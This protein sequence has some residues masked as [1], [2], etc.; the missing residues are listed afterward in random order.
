MLVCEACGQQLFEHALHC[1][2]C[3]ADVPVAEVDPDAA[4]PPSPPSSPSGDDDWDPDE[5]SRFLPAYGWRRGLRNRVALVS[6]TVALIAAVASLAWLIGQAVGGGPAVPVPVS[7]TPSVTPRSTT[8]PRS[9]VVCTPE[10]ARSTNTSCAVATRVLAAVRTI[11]TDLPD[12][13]RVTIVDPQSS[14]NATYVCTIKSWIE[15]TGSRDARVYVQR[16]V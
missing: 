14:K 12:R 4:Q 8:P 5:T 16:Q 3:G 11:G 1:P 15:C 10:V 6:L 7:S 2:R 9:A 13:F